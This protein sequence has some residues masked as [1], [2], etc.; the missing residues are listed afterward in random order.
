MPDRPADLVLTGGR[1]HTV[2]PAGDVE[3][4]VVRDGRV[5]GLGSAR[6]ARAAIG[7]RTR[8]VELG[9]RMVVPGF[10]DA[11]VH[12]ISS[13]LVRLRCDLHGV[14]GREACLVRI[15]AY[16]EAHPDRPWIDGGGWSMADYPAGL[17]RRED[18]DRVAPGRAVFLTNRDGH[19]AWVSSRAL[20]L[21]GIGP[22][23]TDPP[24]GRIERDADGSPTG[25]LHEGAMELVGR[26][27]PAE[28]DADRDAALLDAQAHLHSL[29]I[30]GWQEAAATA[31]DLAAY[32]RAA[33]R[34]ALTARVVAA[35]AWSPR[36]GID[37]LAT[38]AAQRDRAAVGRLRA[39]SVKLFLDGVL[40]TFTGA[41]L[42]PYLDAA[43]RP[44]ANRGLSFYDPVELAAIVTALDAAGIQAH[45]HA[46]GDGAVRQALDAVAAA[47]AANGPTDS[48][49]HVAHIQVIDPAD[50]GRFAAL[51]VVANAQP[52]WACHDGQMDDLTLPF[53]GPERAR[54]Q[55]PF[56]SLLRAGA[57][58][59]MGS[60]WSVSTPDPLREIEVAVSRVS[61][62]ARGRMEPFLPDERLSLDQA[63]AAFTLGSAYVNHADATSGSLEPGKLADLAVLDRDPFAPDAG[64]IGDGRVVATFVE[65]EAVY[66]DA[67]IGA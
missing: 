17:P 63:L 24:D 5:A 48:R 4:V 66:E 26:L 51:G 7:P 12:P 65:G 6:R 67:A 15:R 58:L 21:A 59:A 41:L 25:V 35:Q 1:V 62:E 27:L 14:R 19:G 3:A 61:D 31:D 60:D 38:V 44:T 28:T 33:E 49:P 37:Q 9:G 42:D 57:R 16:A 2:S 52:Y 30:T 54:R 22:G 11:H 10:V 46:I 43:G 47:R 32:I 20:E 18:L 23:S 56:R 50:L 34:G 39:G 64:P 36:G 8:V 40:E 29:G 55:Y 53:L 13:G 45:F